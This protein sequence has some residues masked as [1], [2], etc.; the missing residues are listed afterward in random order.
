MVRVRSFRH[1][2]INAKLRLLVLV[3]GGV[4]LLLSSIFLVFNEVNLIRSSKIRQLAALAKVLGSNSTAA[5]TFD[6]PA[7][8]REILSSLSS[9]PDVE[10]ACLYD[11]KGRVFAT[12]ATEQGRDFSPLPPEENE[13][14]SESEGHLH[15]L[16]P[17]IHDGER[18]GTVFLRDSMS[19][20]RKQLVRNAATVAMVMAVAFG[21]AIALSSRLQRTISRPILT[22]A[23]AA[24]T[25]SERGDYSIRVSRE[26][27][28]ELGTLFDEFN[29]M[30][31]HIQRGETEL[32]EAHGQLEA[33]VAERTRQLSEANA[34]LSR[35]VA[36]R[37]RTEDQL[38]ATQEE[39][40]RTARRA[41]MAEVATGVL[42]NVGNVLNSVNVSATLVA[43]RLRNSKL[44]D[45]RRSVD[46]MNGHAADLG[47]FISRHPQG[48]QLPA[49]LELV[50]GHLSRERD[51]VLKELL[52]LTKNIDHI[53]TIVSMQQSYAGVAGAVES[54][55]L[56]GLLDD[57][58]EINASSFG[59]HRIE[60]LRD[61]AE[62]PPVRVDRQKLLQI[63]VNLVTNAKDSLAECD[64]PKRTLVA[65]IRRD[66]QN[67]NPQNKVLIDIVDSGVGIAGDN[68]TRVF[69]HGFTTKRHGHGFGLH[70]SAIAARELGGGLTVCSDGPGRGAA[71]TLELPLD[72]LKAPP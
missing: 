47:D 2:S 10:F 22:L 61:Y 71:F 40:L 11:A 53:K 18:I 3:A 39:L 55:S 28:D 26:A 38:Q 7:A 29:A 35:E 65:R 51:A 70:A 60:V 8:A 32:H 36:E 9:Q 4:P 52:S 15:V 1:L 45:L 63:L 14:Y 46:L 16:H 6:D 68:L 17:V 72:P 25:I 30:L 57:A 62:V 41:G 54:V 27:N 23:H 31:A 12:Y 56:A 58:L 5:L 43:D 66:V 49:F 34:E 20:L 37:I 69:S 48:K 44:S 67:G 59:K 64:C 33:R 50:S 19:D 13:D 24:Q 42:H 21:A